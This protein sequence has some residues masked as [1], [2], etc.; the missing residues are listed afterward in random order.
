MCRLSVIPTATRKALELEVAST[1]DDAHATGAD[2]IEDAVAANH[3]CPPSSEVTPLLRRPLRRGAGTSGQRPH[4]IVRVTEG[5]AV[6][7]LL[8]SRLAQRAG[9]DGGETRT[10]CE[11]RDHQCSMHGRRSGP[12]PCFVGFTTVH[13][14]AGA[15]RGQAVCQFCAR[16]MRQ[17]MLAIACIGRRALVLSIDSHGLCHSQPTVLR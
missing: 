1:V 11:R 2:L 6:S 10:I 16:T 3:T 7:L 13:A 9:L 15:A 8:G 14:Q 17:D 5:N 12:R 4:A